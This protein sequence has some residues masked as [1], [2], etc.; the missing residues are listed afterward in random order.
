MAAFH[1]DRIDTLGIAGVSEADLELGGVVL[2]LATPSPSGAESAL[3]STTAS[4]VLRKMSTWAALS[5]LQ[6]RPPPSR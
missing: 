6:R 5:D 4:W 2:G 1:V 3:A